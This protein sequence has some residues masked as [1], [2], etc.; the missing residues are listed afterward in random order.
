MNPS[1]AVRLCT[2]ISALS[3]AQKFTDETP[4]VWAVVLE[5][6]TLA[7]AME[8][9]KVLARRQAFIAPADIVPE[10]KR[11]RARR[12]E[13]VGTPTPNVDPSDAPAYAAEQRALVAAVASGVMDEDGRAVYEA[14]GRT[15]SGARAYY[16]LG[17]RLVERPAI[18]A[19]A[20]GAM[21]QRVPH[22]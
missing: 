19:A 15:L 2:L 4:A 7:D 12:L 22:R 20:G 10:A 17:H 3:P 21:R 11:L 1:E 6:V 8:A 5:D 14:G 9:V 13:Q 18:H 16:A